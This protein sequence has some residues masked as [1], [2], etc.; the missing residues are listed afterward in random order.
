MRNE[1][2]VQC[3]PYLDRYGEK[4]YEECITNY[5]YVYVAWKGY[6]KPAIQNLALQPPDREMRFNSWFNRLSNELFISILPWVDVSYDEEGK[7]EAIK[8]FSTKRHKHYVED[9]PL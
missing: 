8:K 7:S 9:N 1:S 5:T 4:K 6:E 3:I 2:L